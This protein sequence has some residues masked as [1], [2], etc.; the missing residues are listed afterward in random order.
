MF[1]GK[2][3]INMSSDNMVVVT[4]WEDE[5]LLKLKATSTRAHN[6]AHLSF[7]DEGT[8]SSSLLWNAIFG[9][10]NYDSLC[11]L[12]KNNVSDL[13]TIP[14]NLKQCEVCILGKHNK[15]HFHGSTS[16]ACRQIEL[17]H[18][19]LCGPMPVPYDLG[20]KSIMNFIDD[21][22]RICWGL[23]VETKVSNI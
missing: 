20:N 19:D 21:Y 11:M 17:I 6:Y 9:N 23:F 15:Q 5:K 22:T 1:D 2:I 12:M 8:F 18:F 14:R 13:P 7:Y 3:E 4:G 10:I 16:K